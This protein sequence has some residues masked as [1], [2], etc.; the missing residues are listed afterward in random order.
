MRGMKTRK[1]AAPVF[2]PYVMNQIALM[3]PSYDEKIPSDHLVRVVN[4]AIENLNVDGLL[5]QYAGQ[6]RSSYH[7]K[8][9]LKIL[10]YGYCKKIYTSRKI[11]AAVRENIHFMWI[12]GENTPDHRT[13]NDFRGKRKQAVIV[14][15]FQAVVEYLVEGKYVKL[16]NYF[17]DGTKIEADGNKHKVVWAKR[18]DRYEEAVKELLKQIEAEN[19]AEEAE[20]GERDLEEMGGRNEDVNGERLKKKIEELNERLRDKLQKR[21]N[22]STRQ[23]LKKLESNCLPRLEKY[24][25]Q[26]KEL[27]DGTAIPRQIQMRPACG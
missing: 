9:M 18:K 10:I 21:E 20:Y 12:A 5:N 13:I 25:E 8:M 7:P 2:K 6:G 27:G 17:V 3:P 16:E 26:T 11:A 22:T 19:E 1:R 4:K 24:E 14:E 23:A 15:V